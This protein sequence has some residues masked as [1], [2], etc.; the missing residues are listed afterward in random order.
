MGEGERKGGGGGWVDGRRG[1]ARRRTRPWSAVP[2]VDAVS[3]QGGCAVTRD[4]GGF[5]VGERRKCTSKTQKALLMGDGTDR[6][7]D[8]RDLERKGTHDH[9]LRLASQPASETRPDTG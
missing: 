4:A 2:T 7:T 1:E 5:V 8:C 9:V 6:L 3:G